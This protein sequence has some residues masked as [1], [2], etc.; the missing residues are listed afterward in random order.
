MDLNTSAKLLVIWTILK[1]YYIAD[2]ILH[3]IWIILVFYC[4]FYT[5]KIILFYIAYIYFFIQK[6]I[7]ITI[8]SL[9]FQVSKMDLTTFLAQL[10]KLVFSYLKSK[11]IEGNHRGKKFFYFG[12]LLKIS[13]TFLRLWHF[14]LPSGYPINSI[15]QW[16]YI[17]IRFL[18]LMKHFSS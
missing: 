18:F 15:F 8:T 9:T 1:W 4:K 13:Q 2:L 17:F 5:F 14:F 7:N 3:S 11:V 16:Q 10:V 6:Y 12:T